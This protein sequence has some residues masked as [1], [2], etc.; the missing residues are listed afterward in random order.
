VDFRID[1]EDLRDALAQAL[2]AMAPER[3]RRASDPAD[4][5]AARWARLRADGWFD[6]F[7]PS[8]PDEDG[9]MVRGVTLGEA[10]GAQPLPEPLE[11]TVGFLL[12]LL[13]HLDGPQVAATGAALRDGTLVAAIAP[14]C[15]GADGMPLGAWALDTTTPIADPDGTVSGA[16]RAVPLPPGASAIVVPVRGSRG[17]SL[18]LLP[19]DRDGV[20]VAPT[21]TIVP[22]RSVAQVTLAQVRVEDADVLAPAGTEL[23]GAARW[24]AAAYSRLLDGIAVGG[25]QA[26]LDRTLAYVAEREQFGAAI[27][28]FQAVKHQ[29][30][31]AA[32]LLEGSRSLAYVAAWEVDARGPSGA[33]ATTLAASRLSAASMYRRVAEVGIQLR[34]ATGFTWEDGAHLWLRAATF[35]AAIAT[36]RSALER[37]FSSVLTALRH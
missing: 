13:A 30:A 4:D 19:L 18:L 36:D 14:S 20:H 29:V 27:G 2:Q 5:G 22:G 12:P 32:V 25:A 28:S 37:S 31:D 17:A 6:A 7:L 15:L 1:A 8:D 3:P 16:L 34:G 11:A 26:V 21:S 23:A 9:W 35:D 24:A 33:A 10:L